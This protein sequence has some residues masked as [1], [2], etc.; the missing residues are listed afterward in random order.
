MELPSNKNEQTALREIAKSIGML[1]ITIKKVKEILTGEIVIVKRSISDLIKQYTTLEKVLRS[2]S[3]GSSKKIN[4]EIAELRNIISRLELKKG[5]DGYTPI[6]GKDYFDG[7]PGQKGDPGISPDPQETIDESVREVLQI[8]SARLNKLNSPS[9]IRDS[10]ETLSGEDRLDKSAIKGFDVAIKE[11]KRENAGVNRPMWGSRGFQLYVDGEK[12]G[13][14]QFLDI[15]AGTGITV[16]HTN[17]NREHVLVIGGGISS[18]IAGPGIT[19]V[20]DGSGHYTV[21][22]PG[23]TTDEKVKYDVNDP[24]AGYVTDKFV[25]G[26]GITLSEGTG[27]D[28]NKLKITNSAPDQT[29]AIT[30]SGIAVVTGTYPN[31]NIDV[32]AETDPLSLHLNQATPQT[33]THLAAPNGLLNVTASVLGVDTTNY[34]STL[35][36]AN[37]VQNTTGT[38]NLVGDSTSPGNSKYY[39]T[40][41]GGTKGFHSI[42]AP[43]TSG[44]ISFQIG[45]GIDPI[46]NSIVIPAVVVPKGATV[47]KW[48]VIADASGSIVVNIQKTTYGALSFASIAGSD[49][50]TLTT[51]Q[52]N[53]SSALTGWTTVITAEDYLKAVVLSATT[54]KQ[55][56]VTIYLTY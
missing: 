31:F 3:E 29:V 27:A 12:K 7:K 6:K 43:T 23:S 25:A 15:E 21:S 51:Q 22:A 28:E 17:T 24:T 20:D 41:S 2:D 48:E 26:T 45:N 38:V 36:F 56:T 1:A 8:I 33:F 44:S 50:P 13:L 34:Q 42:S 10:L 35:S 9:S 53:T 52:K 47:T 37:S 55:V 30:D 14:V 4:G 19:A 49:L 54:V 40:D 46:D 39:G 11:A 5:K 32:S 18:I 16:T